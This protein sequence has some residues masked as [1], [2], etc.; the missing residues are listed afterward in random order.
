MTRL[1]SLA[2][3]QAALGRYSATVRSAQPYTLDTIRKLLSLLGDPQEQFASLHIAGT[4]GKT[5]TAYFLRSFLVAAGC[6]TGLTVSPHIDSIL[7]RIQ[8]GTKPLEERLFLGYLEHLLTV[9]EEAGLTPSYFELLIA[10]AYEVFLR[11]HVRYAVVETGLGGLLDGTNSISRPDKISIITDIGLDHTEVLGET[12]EEIA[13]QKAGIIHPGNSVVLQRQ[14]APA[15]RVVEAA[16][17]EQHATVTLVPAPTDGDPQAAA[18]PPFQRRNWMVARTAYELLA[19][20]DGLPPFGELVLDSPPDLAP[21]G[22]MEMHRVADRLVILDG[23]HN[24]QKLAAFLEALRASGHTSAGV[25]AT[26][27]QAPESKLVAALQTLRPMAAT[28]II[29]EFSVLQDVGKRSPPAAEMAARARDLGYPDVRAI[30]DVKEAFAALLRL[31]GDVVIVTGS[32]Y[33]V[34]QVRRLIAA[35]YR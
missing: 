25:L 21:P 28:L 4:S 19:A 8:I 26:L 14:G 30:P 16:A 33:L 12:I 5:S 2:E 29:P 9:V 27:V 22:R 24:P 20:R 3:A 32:L 15:M 31:D 17:A 23:A 34:S 13:F 35:D 1:A 11:E 18:L 7:E 6:R 10:L